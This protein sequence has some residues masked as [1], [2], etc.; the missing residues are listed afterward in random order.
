MNNTRGVDSHLNSPE[1]ELSTALESS[2][3][4]LIGS[5]LLAKERIKKA[6]QKIQKDYH[7]KMREKNSKSEARGKHSFVILPNTFRLIIRHIEHS[8]GYKRSEVIDVLKQMYY[9]GLNFR[10]I[11]T[12]I[13]S[14]TV[15]RHLRE[16]ISALNLDLGDWKDVSLKTLTFSRALLVDAEK[17]DVDIA[18]MFHVV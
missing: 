4:A 1:A 13:G 5:E 3:D 14:D 8:S 9:R 10:M 2:R 12:G 17:V 15:L 7:I 16:A 18:K 6:R 11:D